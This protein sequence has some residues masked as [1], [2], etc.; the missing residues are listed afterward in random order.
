MTAFN[1]EQIANHL[2]G[3]LHGDPNT[4]V[5]KI[6]TLANATSTCIGFLANSKY[7][8]QLDTTRAAA[9]L[10]SDD[11]LDYLQA[12][13]QA[14]AITLSNPY[15]AYAKLAQLMDTTPKQAVGIAP[16]AVVDET[17][18]IATSAAI[19]AN[20]VISAGAVIEADVTIGA[21]CFVGENSTI[22]AGTRLWANVSVYH[23][24]T[25]GQ[26]CL[27]QSGTV[28]GSDGFGYAPD[29]K[30]W[31]KI[32]QLGGV[33]IG[34]RVEI[35]ANTCVDRGALDDTV[36]GNGVIIDNMCQIAHNVV[37]GDNVAMAGNSGVAGSSTVGNNVSLGGHAGIAGHL[38]I[39]DGVI[40][41]A[42]SIVTNNISTPGMVS[43]CIS[44]M[45]VKDWRR[46]NARIRQ[47]DESHKRLRENEKAISALSAKLE[48][49]D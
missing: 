6:A 29:G 15:L 38:E 48:Q 8:K 26:N 21:N 10:I 12:N 49:Q 33:R 46:A 45:P 14:A 43:S 41:A 3:T 20:A 28:I 23:D 16:S 17:A 19:G 18:Q 44:A 11:D 25:M 2:G 9:V 34:D 27:V 42:Q 5:E 30:T 36:I 7:K 24:V 4:K 39:C 13:S 40:V 47:L 37:L 35:G 1:L 31:V 32:P 22:G